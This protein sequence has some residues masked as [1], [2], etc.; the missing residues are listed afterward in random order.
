[1]KIR[2]ATIGLAL[3]MVQAATAQF[4]IGAKAGAN[5]VKVDG[6]SFKDQF[7]YGYHI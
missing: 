6:I 4:R 7:R 5:I 3:L 1:M 2:L